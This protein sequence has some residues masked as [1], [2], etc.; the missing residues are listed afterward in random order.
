L[1][2]GTHWILG[3]TAASVCLLAALRHRTDAFA[4]AVAVASTVIGVA[5][6]KE[7]MIRQ[8]PPAV[9]AVDHAAGYSFPSGHAAASLALFGSAASLLSRAQPVRVRLAIWS[10]TAA[11]LV[12]IG[13]TRVYLG[14]HYPTDIAAGWLLAGALTTAAWALVSRHAP[15]RFVPAA[16]LH[17]LRP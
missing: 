14:V 7:L 11:L 10:A 9:E 12:G 17:R 5:V 3:L 2:G 15:V 6:V 4:L 13:V 1:L 16:V 8:R